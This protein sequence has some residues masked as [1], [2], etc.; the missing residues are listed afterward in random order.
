[1][2]T[3]MSD[4]NELNPK[5]GIV[6]SDLHVFARRSRAADCLKSLRADLA[7]A[8]VL[9]LNGDTFDFRWSTLRDRGTTV[10]AAL[11]WLR[12]LARDLPGCRIHYVL[13][14][15]DWLGPFRGQLAALAAAQPRLC[16]HEHF[17]RLGPA[18]FLHGD[19]AHQP[20]DPDGLRRYRA[21]WEDDPQRGALAGGAYV[22]ADTLGLT[23]LA[24]ER[25]FPTPRT[26]QR[27]IHYLD[28]ASPGWQSA[29]RDCYFGHTHLAFSGYRHDGIVFHNTGSAIRGT[30][31]NP[32]SFETHE[33]HVA[34]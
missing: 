19:C 23:R 4:A 28:R 6:L 7:S 17:L 16:C 9:V 20:M 14:N 24:H 10:A 5:R 1:L 21:S 11:D 12:A 34:A 8:D 22:I 31:F 25:H 33:E 18:L 2:Q 15:H 3:N 26:V 30:A 13:G 29:I 27:I 32:L